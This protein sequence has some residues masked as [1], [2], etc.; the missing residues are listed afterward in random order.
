MRTRAPPPA[1]MRVDRMGS[2]RC[3]AACA[4]ANALQRNE[5]RMGAEK[6]GGGRL[7]P[8]PELRIL[9]LGRPLE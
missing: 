3:C 1:D 5:A 7:R 8:L 6:G 2:Q 9:V 4:R